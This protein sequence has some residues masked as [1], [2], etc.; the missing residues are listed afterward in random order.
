MITCVELYNSFMAVKEWNELR[1]SAKEE[2]VVKWYR[3][4]ILWTQEEL[5]SLASRFTHKGALIMGVGYGTI[6]GLSRLVDPVMLP[7]GI[8]CA[9]AI[10]T[11]MIVH[12]T[13]E[14]VRLMRIEQGLK[15]R[16]EESNIKWEYEDKS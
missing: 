1:T 15:L 11:G 14:A 5:D 12:H 10:E 13:N 3:E 2:E 7:L 16:A 9:A 8:V 6:L 4:R